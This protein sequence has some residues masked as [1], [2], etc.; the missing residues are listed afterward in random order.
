MDMPFR[1]IDHKTIKSYGEKAT[2]YVI[3]RVRSKGILVT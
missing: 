1:K 2:V 3:D